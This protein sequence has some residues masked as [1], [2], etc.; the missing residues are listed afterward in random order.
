M[1]NS[2]RSSLTNFG[3]GTGGN[4]GGQVGGVRTS[5]HAV[6]A[7]H[8]RSGSMSS[9]AASPTSPRGLGFSFGAHGHGHGRRKSQGNGYGGYGC[10]LPM[11]EEREFQNRRRKSSAATAGTSPREYYFFGCEDLLTDI[12]GG[13]DAITDTC[14]DLDHPRG[15]QSTVGD[16]DADRAGG[17]ATVRASRE[18]E[19]ERDGNDHDN[20]G[21]ILRGDLTAPPRAHLRLSIHVTRSV[22]VTKTPSSPVSA[23]TG[24]D[25]DGQGHDEKGMPGSRFEVGPGGPP[26]GTFGPKFG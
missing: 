16:A 10:D 24:D 5:I 8:R 6:H 26:S 9:A 20:D 19:R 3:F 14:T 13:D 11:V 18:R 17:A 2:L 1:R 12:K 23:H 25:L 4:K 15:S 7:S 21:G 22:V